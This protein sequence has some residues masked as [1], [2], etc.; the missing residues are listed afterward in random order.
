MLELANA[1]LPWSQRFSSGTVTRVMQDWLQRHCLIS[2][3]HPAQGESPI[4]QQRKYNSLEI[5]NYKLSKGNQMFLSFDRKT[6]N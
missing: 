2:G 3:R 5:S 6:T 4:S 1:R